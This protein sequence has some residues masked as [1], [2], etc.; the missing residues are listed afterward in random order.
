M[1]QSFDP[2]VLN[3]DQIVAQAMAGKMSKGT[4]RAGVFANALARILGFP[5][6]DSPEQ[7]QEQRP[8]LFAL[9]AKA[10]VPF[11]SMAAEISG[12]PVDI[13]LAQTT[14][15]KVEDFAIG[16]IP[17]LAAGV[18]TSPLAVAGETAAAN[19]AARAAP[20]LLQKAASS[21]LGQIV[22]GQ[23][24]QETAFLPGTLT[25][26]ESL[27]EAG[28]QTVAGVGLGSLIGKVLDRKVVAKLGENLLQNKPLTEGL[29]EMPEELDRLFRDADIKPENLDAL[30]ILNTTA[31]PQVWLPELAPKVADD[32]FK[33]L[34]AFGES[35]VRDGKS[36]DELRTND[37]VAEV[38]TTD[39][40]ISAHLAMQD[41]LNK[42]FLDM[43]AKGQVTLGFDI[44]DR[45]RPTASLAE[46][47]YILLNG[48][49]EAFASVSKGFK[50]PN[51][52]IIKLIDHAKALP[53][54]ERGQF[55]FSSLIKQAEI[56]KVRGDVDV[57]SPTK[58]GF[59]EY[60]TLRLE[61][62]ELNGPFYKIDEIKNDPTL[63]RAIPGK[64]LSEMQDYAL[65]QSIDLNPN[66]IRAQRI[67]DYDSM[68]KA[69]E[70]GDTKFVDELLFKRVLGTSRRRVQLSDLAEKVRTN[71]Y[72]LGEIGSVAARYFTEWR[73]V[74][75]NAR[76]SGEAIEDLNQ[77]GLAIHFPETSVV[78]GKVL[79][80]Q[81]VL[82]PLRGNDLTDKHLYQI[83]AHEYAHSAER[84]LHQLH[85][86][87]VRKN[88][89]PKFVDNDV[90]GLN[91]AIT[92]AAI[93]NDFRFYNPIAEAISNIT[94]V[95]WL[96]KEQRFGM[97]PSYD[98]R[99]STLLP[100]RRADLLA[101]L[102][103]PEGRKA[104]NPAARAKLEPW[105]GKIFTEPYEPNHVM[106][107]SLTRHWN[108]LQSRKL[109]GLPQTSP[110]V[111]AQIRM[112]AVSSA[113]DPEG[114]IPK[115]AQEVISNNGPVAN[116]GL[117]QIL[118]GSGFQKPNVLKDL[119]R[120]KN[121]VELKDFF[122]AIK[123][124]RAAHMVAGAAT[125][126][127]NVASHIGQLGLQPGI[128]L[129]ASGV[130][131]AKVAS[132]FQKERQV[133]AG[134]ALAQLWGNYQQIFAH[135]AAMPAA[136]R[137]FANEIRNIREQS[138][139][140]E[141]LS[142]LVSAIPSEGVRN[143]VNIVP[144]M[145]DVPFR[146]LRWEDNYFFNVHF[147]GNIYR[148]AYAQA[149]KEGKPFE[150][151]LG[152]IGKNLSK[153]EEE[154]KA[155]V[156]RASKHAEMNMA[157][158]EIPAGTVGIGKLKSIES[159][160]QAHGPSQR[161]VAEQL[162][163][164][165]VFGKST[166]EEFI[167]DPKAGQISEQLNLFGKREGGIQTQPS[168]FG[169]NPWSVEF[170]DQNKDEI[171][172]LAK[173][174][175]L[176]NVPQDIG[177]SK[178]AAERAI[179]VAREG[180]RLDQFLDVLDRMDQ[181]SG[182]ALSILALPFRRTPAYIIREGLRT[183]PFGFLGVAAQALNKQVPLDLRS[184]EASQLLGQAALGTMAFY[185]I[186]QMI[187][188]G[189]IQGD[190]SAYNPNKAQRDTYAAAGHKPGSIH[191]NMFGETYTVPL[192]RLQPIGGIISGIIQYRDDINTARK[193][194]MSLDPV[195]QTGVGLAWRVAQDLG[196]GDFS[197]NLG[198]LLDAI[199]SPK[200]IGVYDSSKRYLN[201]L[202]A[203]F[204]PAAFRQTRLGLG[205]PYVAPEESGLLGAPLAGAKASLG[206]GDP[207]VG[208][209]GQTKRHAVGGA[210]GIISGGAIGEFPNDPIVRKMIEVGAYHQ[211]PT[212]VDQLKDRPKKE[213]TAFQVGK[214]RLQRQFVERIVLN[215][216]FN[217]LN[218]EA[219]KRLINKA[220]NNASDLAN[221]RA[222]A[223]LKLKGIINENTIFRGRS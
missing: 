99:H 154:A 149:L 128:T 39:G 203:S 37:D 30:D 97:P 43:S 187:E 148:Q 183:S 66:L 173:Q 200:E 137:E 25:H 204:V 1:P 209:F 70:R 116:Q 93:L 193:A 82:L 166:G 213:Q 109:G 142:K 163:Q 165:Q 75:I 95:K 36:A 90:V 210:P 5:G 49:V 219:Q 71:L 64:T 222:K 85:V 28:I 169:E 141:A 80:Q 192:D 112:S 157:G 212:L 67:A 72:Q 81:K 188:N 186:W 117:A 158:R 98:H 16:T 76:A 176:N 100:E 17:Y 27:P 174:Y 153:F 91:N 132:G 201:H 9:S 102:T 23:A 130:D 217:K 218:P 52:T 20:S 74:D 206:I 77:V 12:P 62:E 48:D 34:E 59:L 32:D 38:Y 19:F 63:N 211:A 60:Q 129:A 180:K 122:L 126:L 69:L 113:M 46:R 184:R 140:P 178:L 24:A 88:P 103:T 101:L 3:W 57:V 65:E 120:A 121:K 68:F 159:N 221:R 146:A 177:E 179:F 105:F 87:Q 51:N 161:Q 6:I 181:A 131:L 2:N 133:F 47:K 216:G 127:A 40:P 136:L 53:V 194:G 185:T 143:V 111:E 104:I 134:E 114:N 29:A 26:T 144:K 115:S 79:G 7:T 56:A 135:N 73:N 10:G 42:T 202:G 14:G 175:I 145:V 86:D 15:Q 150:K 162:T 215:P 189:F 160:L 164:S 152:E 195:Y 11:S 191:I 118:D 151:A 223:A 196:V 110:A 84:R 33:S 172:R 167:H 8:D 107:K 139:G 61:Q 35:I 205:K 208:L 31:P 124:T 54:E 50:T 83:A 123:E 170:L 119:D 78:S 89:P 199:G 190:P 22:A 13:P 96:P 147:A 214:G 198:D 41:K 94:G 21:R 4:R 18:L 125:H 220:F 55:L 156:T 207:K 155:L 108:V 92:E 58:S 45:V 138:G 171:K 182:G 106:P 44:L 168:L 197:R